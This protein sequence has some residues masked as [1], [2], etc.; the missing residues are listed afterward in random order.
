[1]EKAYWPG[2]GRCA[3]EKETACA[4]AEVVY[5]R[6][7]HG[8]IE[9]DGLRPGVYITYIA[10]EIITGGVASK[11]DE[12][13]GVSAGE[14]RKDGQQSKSQRSQKFFHSQKQILS[15]TNIRHEAKI[16]FIFR[17]H[18]GTKSVF[19]QHGRC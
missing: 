9:R 15:N 17:E 10:V 2:G 3:A 18:N 16:M 7:A 11:G 1:M 12:L 8:Q 19:C 13:F 14:N 4:A 6:A 5:Q